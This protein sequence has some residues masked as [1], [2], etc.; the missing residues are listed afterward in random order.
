MT[1]VSDLQP[2]SVKWKIKAANAPFALK[3]KRK[4]TTGKSYT[5]TFV[6]TPKPADATDVQVFPGK[7]TTIEIGFNP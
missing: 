6:S 5:I 2:A 1:C 7:T 3:A 4:K